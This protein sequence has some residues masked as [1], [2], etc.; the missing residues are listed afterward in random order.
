MKVSYNWLKEYVKKLPP[1]DELAKQLTM[2]GLEVEG[3][4]ALDKGVSGV[5]TAQILSVEKHPNADRLAFCKV[6]SNKGI[7]AIVCGAKN[8]KAGD[9]VALA[10]PGA[11]LPKGIKIEKTKI[12]GVESEG[13]M[14]SESE[15][16]LKDTSEGI[17]ILPQGLTIGKDFTEA[18]GLNDV[19]LN[20]NVTPNRPDC[21]SILGIARE[22]AAITGATVRSQKSEVRSKNSKLKT[23]NSK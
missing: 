23:K 11:T 18:M 16:G 6:K 1:P 8:M 2:T 13:M 21:L 9:K 15:L 7:H 5:V 22:V 20:V 4:E 19:I 3:I 14:C 10:L 12:R 17:M